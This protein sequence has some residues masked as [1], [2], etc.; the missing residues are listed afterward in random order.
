MSSLHGCALTGSLAI[1]HVVTAAGLVS[2]AST[3]KGLADHALDMVTEQDCRI[4]DGLL[5]QDRAICEPVGSL[6]T[7]DDFKGLAIFRGETD[8]QLARAERPAED[9]LSTKLNLTPSLQDHVAM[10]PRIKPED[11]QFAR[12]ELDTS[13]DRSR[14][15]WSSSQQLASVNGLLTVLR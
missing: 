8:S 13:L 15:I 9:S 12:L 2:L 7:R 6:A 10:V 4:L 1:S 14:N 3:G 11:G 5:R